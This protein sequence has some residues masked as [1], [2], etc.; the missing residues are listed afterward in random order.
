MEEVF[1][2]A[3]YES[4]KK[5][6]ESV[7]KCLAVYESVKRGEESVRGACHGKW[8]I[9]FYLLPLYKKNYVQKSRINC[10]LDYYEYHQNNIIIRRKVPIVLLK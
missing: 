1:C 6:E 7:K 3:L 9:A 8:N 5:G 4:E 2:L 10:T